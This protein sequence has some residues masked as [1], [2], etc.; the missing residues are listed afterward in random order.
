MATLVNNSLD[1]A[2]LGFVHRNGFKQLPADVDGAVVIIHGSHQLTDVD[3]VVGDIVRLKWSVSIVI[4]DEEGVFPIN[5]LTG[6]RRKV[7]IQMPIPKVHDIADRRL[8][9]G[10]PNDAPV[11][12]Q[13]CQKEMKERPLNWFYS[14]QVNHQRRR[15]CIAQLKMTNHGFLFESPTFWG[16]LPRDEYYQKLAS[17]KVAPCP[18]G[19][20]TPDTF[21]V[22]ESLE[23]GCVPVVEDKWPPFF[24]RLGGY[25]QTGYWKLVLGEDPPFPVLTDWRDWPALI[26]QSLRDWPVNRDRLQEWWKGY[27]AKMTRWLEEDVN[28]VR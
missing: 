24:P 28:A 3:A 4:C 10:Y 15:E 27:K 7:W 11:Y 5:R 19:A 25:G 8:I 1:K 16:G 20:A 9:C 6:L 13:H 12:L 14:G 23:A 2:E 26:D 21:R 17:C 22:W 18:S